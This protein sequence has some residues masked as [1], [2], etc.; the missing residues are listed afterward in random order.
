M[1]KINV[2]NS[3]LKEM[4]SVTDWS[5]RLF[6]SQ[7]DSDTANTKKHDISRMLNA[8]PEETLSVM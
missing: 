7:I 4:R 1:L 3:C 2:H 6:Q 8:I 5:S